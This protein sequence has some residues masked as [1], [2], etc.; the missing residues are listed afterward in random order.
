MFKRRNWEARMNKELEFHLESLIADYKAQGL[1][2]AQAEQQARLDFGA[3]ELAKDECRDQ[4]PANWLDNLTRDIRYTART[5]SR[6][7]G[8]AIAAILTFALGI[9]ANTAIFSVVYAALIKPLPYAIPDQIYSAEVA[10][11]ER[12]S[13][14]VPVQ[15]FLEW[16][17]SE[18]V[19]S[20]I[21]AL[22]PWECSLS[23]DGEPERLGGAKVSTNFFSFLGVPVARG[24]DFAA[25]EEQPGN[26]RVIV[27][28]DALWRRRYGAGPA[29][30]GKSIDINGESHQI[31][32]V[33]AP[34][35]LVPTGTLLNPILA[36]APR[37]DIWKPIAPTSRDLQ[38]ESWDHGIFVRL[39]PDARLEQGR[40]QFQ[41]ILTAF[42]RTVAPGASITFK[43]N[44]LPVREVYAGKLRL[45]LLFV[46]AAAAL[47][48]LTACTNIANL[49]L[50]RLASRSTEFATRVALGAGRARLLSQT[51]TETTVLALAGAAFGIILATNSA[52]LLSKLA[53]E[54][55]QLLA[56]PPLN[57]P[58]L[59]FAL[60]AAVV[61]GVACGLFPALHT[62]NMQDSARITGTSTR[63]RQVLIGVEMAL[64]T[65]LL[66]TTGLLIH[67]FVKVI[68]AD[69][70]YQIERILS[71]DLSLFGPRYGPA[72]SR[73][74]F[75]RDATDNL[76]AI[77]GITAAGAISDSPAANSSS[78]ASRTIFHPTDTDFQHTVFM[79]PV[80]MV[81]AV[82]SGYFAASGTALRAGR[83]FESQEP[84]PTALI[85]ESLAR[86]LWPNEPLPSVIGRGIRQG[87]V[88]GPVITIAGVVE[89]VRPGAADRESP[90]VI[91]RPHSQWAS[92]PA[93]LFIRTAQDPATLAPAVREAIRGMDANLPIPAI[94]TM[95]EIVL[96][97]VSQRRFQLILTSLFALLALLLGAIGVYGVVS[98]SV[99]CRT[100]EIGLR[101]ALGAMRADIL[102]WIISTGMKPVFIGLTV[103]LAAAIVMAR[104]L[105]SQLFGV[106]PTD[107]IS[108]GAV[109][110]V[111]LAT[112]TLACYLPARRAARLDPLTALRH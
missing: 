40:Q 93:T 80:A 54:D 22:R 24:R 41:S 84:A 102:R 6:N 88:T 32:G 20:A 63:F 42:Y 31:I 82:T 76:R 43:I 35:L 95:R 111:L 47:L 81:R 90:P 58:A 7:P 50:A 12:P 38:N 2:Q 13:M 34:S 33:A 59:L 74:A 91:Y 25:A 75:Y 53:G 11:P 55:L 26:D 27:I 66:A 68:N 72:A 69:R 44:L 107:P 100:R 15:A 37:V 77:P 71:V 92:G 1:T 3:M 73:V 14:P 96:E 109:V 97:S 45:R 86:N 61:T 94:R 5:L 49:F 65:A 83:H 19:F 70:G 46:L 67:S 36:F 62:P 16:R 108:L 89:D 39:R 57:L 56:A 87:N 30:I 52:A 99:E 10:L 79:R 8:F 23:G 18:T 21:A 29:V 112:S 101:M 17:K 106:T 105:R 60:F 9:G 110:L 28:S 85:S 64:G 78:G 4:K 104:L 51:L 103:G 98:Y 48:L